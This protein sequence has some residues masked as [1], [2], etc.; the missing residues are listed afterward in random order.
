M[1]SHGSVLA[2]LK[3]SNTFLEVLFHPGGSA[4]AEVFSEK[5]LKLF[6]R[7]SLRNGE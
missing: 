6:L 2:L 5:N 4:N 1:S 7:N 3:T